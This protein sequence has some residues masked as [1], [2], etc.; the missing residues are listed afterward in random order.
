MVPRGSALLRC[1]PQCII[2]VINKDLGLAAC[3]SP[4]YFHSFQPPIFVSGFCWRQRDSTD[5]FRERPLL[6]RAASVLSR[7]DKTCQRL[8]RAS[9]QVPR[10]DPRP[11]RPASWEVSGAK[12][13][14]VPL[15]VVLLPQRR[16]LRLQC[17]VAGIGFSEALRIFI[18]PGM[19]S[20][21]RVVSGNQRIMAI[22]S[23]PIM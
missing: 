21:I 22:F 3:G 7:I 23:Y 1:T 17:P 6:P 13:P 11:E 12:A 15:I 10:R 20:V 19:V 2:Q 5:E 4:R 9:R 8:R 18:R 16:N 14:P